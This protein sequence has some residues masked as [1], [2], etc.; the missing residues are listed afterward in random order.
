MT[1]PMSKEKIIEHLQNDCEGMIMEC[2]T[3]FQE[4]FPRS[5]IKK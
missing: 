5:D 4:P 2:T 1:E 3:C